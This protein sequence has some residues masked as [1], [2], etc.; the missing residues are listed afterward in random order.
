MWFP[1]FSLFPT[2]QSLK[3]RGI[4]TFVIE[5]A[6]V[7][8]GSSSFNSMS[9]KGYLVKDCVNCGSTILGAN[10]EN[11][12]W[13]VGGMIDFSNP[14]AREWWFDCKHCPLIEGCTVNVDKCKDSLPDP[15]NPYSQA[16]PIMGMSCLCMFFSA[17]VCALV[18]VVLVRVNDLSTTCKWI[19]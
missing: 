3:D 11:H 1:L 4:G 19:G 2:C 5:E 13:G 18:K 7:S 15:S 16:A 8:K 14:D 17:G 9:N 12:W 6:Y 10:G